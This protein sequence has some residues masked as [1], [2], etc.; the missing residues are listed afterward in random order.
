MGRPGSG[1]VPSGRLAASWQRSEAYGVTREVVEPVFAGTDPDESLFLDCGREVITDLH[2]TLLDEPVSLVLTDADGLVLE[3]R[4]GDTSLLRALDAVHLAPGFAFSERE[5]G[6]NGL[7][8]ALADRA[9]AVVA[10]A[11]HYNTS[12]CVYTCAAVPVLDPITGRLEGAV[13]LTTWSQSSSGLLLALAQSAASSTAA[14]ML[15]R[16]RG[17]TA[18][19]TPRGEVFR[20]MGAGL[21]PGTG[22]LVG[23]SAAWTD[24]RRRVE[25][26][27]D[28][29]RVVL[30]VGE[31]GSGR[32]CLLAQAQRRAAPH[33]RILSARPPAEHDTEA[34][35]DLWRPELDAPHTAVVV[36][37]AD[38]L[39][40][41]V[42]ERLRAV[43]ETRGTAVTLALT[44]QRFAD[45]PARLA[46]L[47]ETVV[48]V[49]ALRER[50]EDVLPLATHLVAQARGREVPLT[51][52]AARALTAYPW[53]GNVTQLRH[54]VTEA[55]AH[56]DVVD[57]ALLPAEVVHGPRRGLSRIEHVER[58]EIARVLATPGQTMAGAA[59]QLGISRA[60]LYRKV[61]H[62]RLAH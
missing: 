46:A 2:R 18:R 62:Y 20:V 3:R 57:V 11:Q 55:A 54:V 51:A 27:L 32:A 34:W 30:A 42:A 56:A 40:A 7:G 16:S 36:R 58:D 14:L 37:D 10:A 23:L 22:S 44:A 5:A 9:P 15:A 29:G 6:T 13:N 52:A 61:A 39:S 17:R 8:L 31:R 48:E 21:E 45:V 19:P 26:A 47:V 1:L 59:R 35:L 60:T 49:P 4:S 25:D 43:V 24:A 53:P 28:H 12:L 41:S 50:P 33:D 38:A